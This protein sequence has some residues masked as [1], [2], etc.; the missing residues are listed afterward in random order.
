VFVAGVLTVAVYHLTKLYYRPPA[1]IERFTWR[2][3]FYPML[4]WAVT[5]RLHVLRSR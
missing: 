3:R 5:S 1:D 4:F 2:R